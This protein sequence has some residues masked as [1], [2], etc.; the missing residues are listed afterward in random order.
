MKFSGKVKNGT[1]NRSLSFGGDM[2]HWIQQLFNVFC[3]IA[4]IS[5]VGD[6]GPW[7]RYTL[8]EYSCY[9]YFYLIVLPLLTA[10]L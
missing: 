4:L 7:Q 6:F 5:S 8:L 1:R 3:V 10:I 9:M 2:D